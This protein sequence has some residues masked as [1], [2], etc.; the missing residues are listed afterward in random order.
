MLWMSWH[1]GEGGG[2]QGNTDSKNDRIRTIHTLN[3]FGLII[4]IEIKEW[5]NEL[6][7]EE[8]HWLEDY[9]NMMDWM[10]LNKCISN[11]EMIF[12]DTTS[13]YIQP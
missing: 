1:W 3:P 8:N 6:K 7:E 12:T 5:E 10:C 2:T 13:Y 9:V 4:D 11:C